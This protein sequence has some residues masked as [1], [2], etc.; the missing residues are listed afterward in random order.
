M[1]TGFAPSFLDPQSW[2]TASTTRA[3]QC[4]WMGN[5]SLFHF[6]RA[7]RAALRWFPTSCQL[8]STFGSSPAKLAL[9]FPRTKPSSLRFRRGSCLCYW[10]DEDH[11]LQSKIPL[12]LPP[13]FLPYHMVDTCSHSFPNPA[14]P[15]MSLIP[16]PSS[17]WI[18][19]TSWSQ[20]ASVSCSLSSN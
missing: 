18:S 8:P 10:E 19:F 16:S 15:L 11:H 3:A 20:L 6:K 1:K 14:F 12:S 2:I 13:S 17:Y 9:H 7:P 4:C 5:A